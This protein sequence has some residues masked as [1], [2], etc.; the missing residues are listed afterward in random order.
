M[1]PFRLFFLWIDRIKKL[2][3]MPASGSIQDTDEPSS[4]RLIQEGRSHMRRPSFYFHLGF[5]PKIWYWL[6]KHRIDMPVD[7]PRWF[8]YFV[9]MD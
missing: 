1:L 5:V 9:G 8:H 7:S 6:R 4:D 2:E 3:R